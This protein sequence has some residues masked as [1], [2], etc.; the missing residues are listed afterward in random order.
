MK[1][2]IRTV[3]VLGLIALGGCGGSSGA[4]KLSTANVALLYV[5]GQG[6]NTIQG[7]HIQGSGDLVGT[8]VSTTA[9]NPR[10]VAMAL[11]PSTNFL[12]VANFASNT[13]SG[14][15]V[16]HTAGI[17]TP[18]GE[19]LAPTPTGPS[20]IAVA[21]DQSGR[22]LFV[23]NQGDETISV[24]S[25]DG[26]R[27]LLTQ[28]GAPFATGQTNLQAM[29][30]SPTSPLVYVLSGPA[31]SKISVFSFDTNGT[32]AS[33]AGSFQSLGTTNIG[34]MTIDPKGQ[35]LYAADSANNGILSL[36]IAQSGALSLVAGSPFP[37]GTKP[38]AVA[39]DGTGSFVYASNAGSNDVSGYTSKAGVLTQVPGSPFTTEGAG[40]V[41]ATQPGFLTV[42]ATNTFLYVS[43]VATKAIAAFGINA[44]DGALVEVTNS[45]FP[46]VVAPSWI[47][48]TK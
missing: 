19:A 46:E 15:T 3:W 28:V 27:G 1:A 34:G 16:D 4:S 22:F 43:N 21:C 33:A 37:A 41:N 17:L 32:L 42:D 13:V 6:Q 30:L 9:T 39:V 26:V 11:H 47:I 20:P 25:I 14:Y 23:L 36:S 2:L 48:T 31:P 18:V 10:P 29:N 12:Y 5:V 45:P 8:S 35:F 38:V 40:T 7:F 24:Y 44:A